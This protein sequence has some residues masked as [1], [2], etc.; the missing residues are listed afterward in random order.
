MSSQLEKKGIPMVVGVKD[1][2]TLG[3]YGSVLQVT[4]S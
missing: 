2:I 3:E 1:V 4:E